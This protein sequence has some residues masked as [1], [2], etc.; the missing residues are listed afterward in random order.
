MVTFRYD[1]IDNVTMRGLTLNIADEEQKKS[2][3][4]VV[5]PP[6]VVPS[7]FL[8][9]TVERM[10]VD[11]FGLWGGKEPYRSLVLRIE[12]V[13]GVEIIPLP[14]KELTVLFNKFLEDPFGELDSVKL[15]NRVVMT[16]V[17]ADAL[18][19]LRNPSV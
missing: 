16:P 8:E 9:E 11:V 5:A 2:V 13:N 4:G 18:G 10:S 17:K 19:Q 14:V 7:S 6:L 3:R 12:G 15:L 1:F